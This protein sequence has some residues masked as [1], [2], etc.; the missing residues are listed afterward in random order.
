[1][2]HGFNQ[3]ALI[4]YRAAADW[5]RARSV[6]AADNFINAIESAIHEILKRP[7]SFQPV[8]DDLRV[9]R[10]RKFPYKIHYRLQDDHVTIYSV[11]HERRKPDYLRGRLI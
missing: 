9:F 10:L 2:T 3:L 11:S 8:G 4:E 6:L 7:D 5:Y 1:M